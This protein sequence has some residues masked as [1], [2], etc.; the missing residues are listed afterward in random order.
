MGFMRMK[1]EHRRRFFQIGL[2]S[3]GLLRLATF[4]LARPLERSEVGTRG[5][6][7]GERESWVGL[8]VGF[9]MG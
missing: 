5:K 2:G 7:E 1:M 3:A 6:W 8:R 4:L 9:L